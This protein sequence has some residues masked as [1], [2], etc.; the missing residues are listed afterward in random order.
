MS[1]KL[2]RSLGLLHATALNMA[3][4]V[5]IGP[6]I[7]IPLIVSAMGGPQAML[8]WVVGA[9]IAICDGQV[10]A[11][12]ATSI[13]GEGGSYVYLR[14]AYKKYVGK[15]MA[16]LFIW[17]FLFSGP[18]EIASGIVGMTNHIGFLSSALMPEHLRWIAFGIGLVTIALQY[19]KVEFVGA[20]TIVL[21]IIMMITVVVTVVVGVS[22]FQASNAFT[23]PKNWFSFSWG[24]ILG[25]GS[26]S[27]IAIYDLMGYYNVCYLEEEVKNPGYVFPRAILWSVVAITGVYA[28]MNLIVLGVMPWQE[29]AAS[30]HIVVDIVQKF[31]GTQAAAIMSILIVLTAYG[32]VYS[33]MTSYSRLPFA[34][35]RDGFFFSGLAA[36][37]PT[38]HF[39]HY[40]LLLVGAM[41]TLA[42]L[43]TLDF[44][45][46][47]AVS[48]RILIQFLG[49]IVGLTLLRKTQPDR[50]RP[51][52]MW[53][54]PIPSCIAF[55]GFLFVFISS[56][57][58]AVAWGLAWIGAGVILFFGW[59]RKNREWPFAV[60]EETTVP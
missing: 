8:G 59:A 32:S 33:L 31:H 37:H 22:H 4:M 19:N 7:T 57:I 49:Q 3:T 35:A 28:V 53:L 21:W 16:F 5:G 12:L 48:S 56:G 54:Y 58:A 39:P 2:N 47:V 60:P 55:I 52:L 9:I 18:F 42:S 51:F 23:F 27:M 13:P 6:F 34:A 46:A 20:F 26:A 14:E 43:F 24:F 36:V 40:S 50:P 29:V 17:T 30:N 41:T 44:I 10:W 25:L 11:E 45:I 1:V 15:L 38:R